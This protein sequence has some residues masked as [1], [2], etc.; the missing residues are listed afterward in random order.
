MD[1]IEYKYYLLQNCWLARLKE[2]CYILDDKEFFKC[3][4]WVHDNE[5]NLRLNDCIMDYGD[6]SV[7]D[8]EEI[9][10]E[11]A[12]EIIA[13]SIGEPELSNLSESAKTTANI[14]SDN[15]IEQMV[16]G[17]VGKRSINPSEKEIEVRKKLSG[18]ALEYL[19]FM[20]DD[21]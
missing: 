18:R 6:Y 2:G 4:K 15:I 12:L 3:G 9:D 14:N 8:Y 17:I 5:L 21:E 19:M 1:K 20:D 7:F 11:K 13:S 10:E 16:D